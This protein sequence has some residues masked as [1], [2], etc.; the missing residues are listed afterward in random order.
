MKTGIPR[1][2]IM[3][4][5]PGE[6]PEKVR[7]EW[8]GV[9]I[10]LLYEQNPK[11]FCSGVMGGKPDSQNIG[12]Y[13]VD[14]EEAIDALRKKNTFAAEIAANWWSQWRKNTRMGKMSVALIFD[15]NVCAVIP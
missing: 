1:I 3:A 13:R 15:K 6:A 14:V 10:P 2:K 11:G 7:K 5:P 8:V 4:V 9:E 12:G